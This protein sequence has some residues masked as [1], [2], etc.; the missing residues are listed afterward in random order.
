VTELPQAKPPR[1]IHLCSKA[2]SVHG[3]SFEDDPDYQAGLSDVWCVLTS[4]GLGPDSA[5]VS[6]DAC[7]DRDRE[8]YREY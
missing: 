7:R 5:D 1:C 4:R 8:C 2:M 3:E 6:L